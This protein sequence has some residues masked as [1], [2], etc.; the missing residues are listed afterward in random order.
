MRI[1]CKA[2]VV[3]SKVGGT[4]SERERERMGGDAIKGEIISY[5]R[6]W[7]REGGRVE[8]IVRETQ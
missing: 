5:R 3:V 8:H 7:R 4:C 6:G 2:Q 1:G